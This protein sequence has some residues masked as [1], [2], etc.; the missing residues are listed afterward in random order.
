MRLRTVLLFLLVVI[1]SVFAYFLIT[2][3]RSGDNP[4]AS[5]LPNSQPAPD[6][7]STG[8]APT[9][10]PAVRLIDVVVANTDIPVGTRLTAEL[11][12][13]V[14]R[15]ETNIALQG[16][17]TI[18]D[19]ADAIGEVVKVDVVRGQEILLPM[20]STSPNDVASI[21]SDAAIYIEPGNVLIAVPIDKYTGAAYAMRPG[22]TTSLMGTY[23]FVEIDPE[24]RTA[25]PNTTQRVIESQL[26]SGQ[27]FL[28]PPTTQGRLEFVEEIS[29]VAE[30]VP[31]DNAIPGQDFDSGSPIPKRVTDTIIP[32]ARVV[33]VGTWPGD[34]TP[35]DE[36]PVGEGT[37]VPTPTP[38]PERPELEPDMVLLS[39]SPQEALV[40]KWA[41]DRGVDI[42][43]GLRAQGDLQTVTTVPVSLPQIIEQGVLI[44]PE[45]TDFDL[46]PRADE[47]PVP[48]V[49]DTPPN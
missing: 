16:G 48:Q 21:G 34:E 1:V 26:L 15:P 46:H 19:P 27:A 12:E 22:D 4:L 42:S 41:L 25:L 17:Y 8:P 28:F 20:L 10:T 9:P 40:V 43:M 45:I 24:F 38:E 2:R 29:Q 44:V 11:I 3:S 31:S 33:W 32:Q 14:R 7:V 37:P 35:E 23:R 36:P 13:V 39:M 18:S 47:V 6:P 49:P 5:I 30:I